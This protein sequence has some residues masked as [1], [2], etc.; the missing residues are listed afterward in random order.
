MNKWILI[1]L[2]IGIGAFGLWKAGV[3]ETGSQGDDLTRYVPADTVLYFGGTTDKAL[4]EFMK[5]YPLFPGAPTS[6]AQ[7]AS[8]LTDLDLGESPFG[9]L[10]TYIINDYSSKSDGSYQYFADYF[11]LSV[12]GA[13]AVY[14]HGAMPVINLPLADVQTFN[15][16]I[17]NASTEAGL[18]YRES[19]LGAASLKSW[20]LEEG[21]NSLDL[22]IATHEQS[23]VITLFAKADTE[24][25][26]SERLA[27][28]PVANSLASAGT[29][30]KLKKSYGYR[31]DMLFLLNIENLVKA[32]YD[33]ESSSLAKDI[34]RYMPAEAFAEFSENLDSSCQEDYLKLFAAV[35][36]MVGGYTA[37]SIEGDTLS[38]SFQML[39]EI[40]N[41]LVTT[42]LQKLQG[43]IP[44]HV[45][46]AK[47]KIF[48][49][50]LGYN[51]DNMTPAL[52][53]L[54]TE[55]TNA[56]FTCPELIEA[57]NE[58]RQTSPVML[59]MVT[60]MAPGLQGAGVSIYD[61]DWDATTKQPKNVSA[62]ISIATTNPQALLSIAQMSPMLAGITIADDGGAS[63]LNLP[64]VPAGVDVYA[65]VKGQNI[66]IYTGEI[67][68]QEAE[69]LS[70][71]TLET[72][73]LYNLSLNYRKLAELA[74]TL[75][76]SGLPITQGKNCVEY[77]EFVHIMDALRLDFSFLFKAV[78]AGMEMG[79]D[80]S[81]DRPKRK[82]TKLELTGSW[83]TRYHD[84]EC[85]LYD[86]G[87]ET[88]NSDGT[89]S[90]AEL[91]TEQNC[92]IYKVAYQWEKNGNEILFSSDKPEL[93]RDSCEEEWQEEEFESY[94]CHIM[95]VE[96]KRFQCVFDAGSEEAGVY[97]YEQL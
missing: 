22:V 7:M 60:G 47:D 41:A 61:F 20:T 53:A 84:E 46:N 51:L 97:F 40:K 21:E 10:F 75:D 50:G 23:A 72:N 52:T 58:A 36:R 67:A 5:D 12:E 45:L 69:K 90:Y 96:A 48:S 35:P 3:F 42:E 82:N 81:M 9:K 2:L 78:D 62:L 89:G 18:S 4:A 73:G 87:T 94:S 34:Q 77:Y 17:E 19:T 54:W 66:V 26:L 83:K 30:S 31:D 49:F 65:A 91:D 15:A 24:E 68:A 43:H 63:K 33:P 13:Y 95:N 32:F 86:G 29:L 56:S 28:K 37:M 79:F 39:L 11:G 85:K 93:Y 27:L 38:S 64:M 14:M 74:E 16:L 6:D 1:L 92:E 71:E 76:P 80:A 25:L 44:S 70:S 59:G 8:L 88:F 55:F 57:Q